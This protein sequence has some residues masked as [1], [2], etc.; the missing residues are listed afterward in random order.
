MQCRAR[1]GSRI[2]GVNAPVPTSLAA[3]RQGLKQLL[4]QGE[5]F[6]AIIC[7]SDTLAQGVIM[8]A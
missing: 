1:P 4:A 7:S 5:R 2:R 6:D 8:E 3:G